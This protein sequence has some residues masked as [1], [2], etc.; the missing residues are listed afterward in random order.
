MSVVFNKDAL[1]KAA[2]Q[3]LAEDERVRAEYQAAVRDYRTQHAKKAVDR[4][5]GDAKALRAALTAELRKSGPVKLSALRASLRHGDLRDRF[6]DGVPDYEVQRQVT[7]P[8]GLLSGE[9]L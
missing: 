1:I 5:R 3:A 7:R 6:Y 9:Q 2:K 4:T 8:K